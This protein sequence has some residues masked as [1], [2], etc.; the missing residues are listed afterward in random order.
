MVGY[1][2]KYD[3]DF[4]LVLVVYNVGLGNVC[5]YGGV[6]LFKEM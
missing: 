6:L 1:I 2:K 4:K 3:G 5:K